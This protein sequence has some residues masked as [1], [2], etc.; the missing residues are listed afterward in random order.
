[1]AVERPK[2]TD[3]KTS[4]TWSLKIAVAYMLILLT[5]SKPALGGMLTMSSLQA[6]D[7]VKHPF[8]VDISFEHCPLYNPFQRIVK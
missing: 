6:D 5:E 3:S 4:Q 7:S 1:M 2:K 8:V